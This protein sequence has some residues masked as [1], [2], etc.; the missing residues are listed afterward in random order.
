MGSFYFFFSKN[1]LVLNFMEIR[2]V[3]SELLHVDGW[4]DTTKVMVAVRYFEKKP[5][6][7]SF[8]VGLRTYLHPLYVKTK[9]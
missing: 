2:P 5:K 1:S 9:G 4:T 7:V 6:I 8:M 3:G